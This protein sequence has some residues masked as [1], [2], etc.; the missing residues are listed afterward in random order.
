VRVR[1]KGPLVRSPG[2]EPDTAANCP[3][4]GIQPAD[5]SR[6]RCRGCRNE[7]T[8][9]EEEVNVKREETRVDERGGVARGKER[10]EI[11]VRDLKGENQGDTEAAK[12]TGGADTTPVTGNSWGG[13]GGRSGSVGRK[14]RVRDSQGLWRLCLWRL[15]REIW[16]A[17]GRAGR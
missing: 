2:R 7:V 5:C 4:A 3:A 12:W 9:E 11:R 14:G 17:C 8:G 6:P 10:W 16:G 13:W 15:S 1:V